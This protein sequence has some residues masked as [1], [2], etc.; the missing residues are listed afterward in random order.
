MLKQTTLQ[1]GQSLVV[2]IVAV[3]ALY[4]TIP[5][6][7]AADPAPAEIKSFAA[8]DTNLDGF[9]DKKEAGA[10]PSLFKGFDSADTDGDGRLSPTEYGKSSSL[11]P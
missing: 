11:K 6:A 9:I 3:A 10:S 5:Q 8:L 7:K 4:A 2:A 1:F